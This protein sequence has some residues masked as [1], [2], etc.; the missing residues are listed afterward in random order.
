MTDLTTM[1]TFE[2]NIKERLTKDIGSLIPDEALTALIEKSIEN[3]F[4][5]PQRKTVGHGYNQ[6][7][8]SS[9]SVFEETV[10]KLLEDKVKECFKTWLDENQEKVFKELSSF[11]NTSSQEALSQ[12]IFGTFQAHFEGLK[13]SVQNEISNKLNGY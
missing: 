6:R 1:Q 4:F 10:A 12:T 8:T 9:P 2:E 5:K 11:I 7:D 3:C 13:F